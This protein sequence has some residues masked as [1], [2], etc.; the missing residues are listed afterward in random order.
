MK[1]GYICSNYPA[2]SHTFVLR[3]VE[4]LRARGADVTTF[5][6]HRSGEDQLLSDAEREAF[7]TTP[8]ILPPRWG[9]LLAAHGRAL[10]RSP[11]AYFSTL[12]ASVRFGSLAPRRFL[13]QVFYF[14]EAVMLW[15]ES[16]SKTIRH[17]HAHQANAASDVAMLAARLGSEIEPEQPWSW[18]FTMHGPTEFFD[19][20]HYRLAEKLEDALFVV[21]ISDF[22]RSQMMSLSGPDA[23]RRLH[24]VHVGIPV[25]DFTRKQP[26]VDGGDQ[27]VLAL[28]R[29][30]PVK[31]HAVLLEA[32]AAMAQDGRRVRLDVAGGGEMQPQLELQAEELG[33]ADLVTFHG[34]VGQG[35]LRDLYEDAT[36]FSLPSFA[37]GI[38]VVLMEAMAMEVPVVTTRITGIPELVEDEVT[39]LLVTPGRPDQVRVAIERLLEGPELRARLGRQGRERV[40]AEFDVE[41]SAAQLYELFSTHL[42]NPQGGKPRPEAPLPVSPA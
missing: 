14:V 29:L 35:A 1:I 21:C 3:E 4:A 37:E 8:T 10:L 11:R 2:I 32:I 42:S 24:V 15:S 39:G 30:H 22:A 19:R 28:G 40:A 41:V 9:Q 34:A 6:I 13:W 36:I 18:S 25:T 7:E 26:P 33:I 5:S 17:L 27:S 20:R 16:H 38:P 12:A 31:G 23:W